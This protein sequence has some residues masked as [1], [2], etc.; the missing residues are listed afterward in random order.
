MKIL[1]TGRNGQVGFELGRALAPL[2]EICAVDQEDGDFTKEASIRELVR[3]VRPD[4]VANP[5][6]YTA[7]DRAESEPSLAHAVNAVAPGVIGEEADKLGALVIHYSTDYVFDGRKV[8]FYTEEDET[9]PLNVY[10]RSKRAGELALQQATTRHLILRTSW[11]V[12][13]HGSNFAKTILRLAAERDRLK[14]V[15]DQWGA[16]TS[17]ALLADVTAHLVRE[18]QQQGTEPFPYG[19]YHVVAG[20]ETTWC[21]YARFVVAEALADGQSLKLWPDAIEAIPSSAYPTAATRPAN[22]RLD[23]SKFRGVFHLS[24]PDW[25][26]GVRYVL[27]QLWDRP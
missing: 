2:G 10:G 24:L 26:D 20:G 16:P 23:T 6:A 15:A 13:A 8:G 1:L 22:S 19:L 11:V 18:W 4:V 3:R 5:A 25:R 27:R 17:A 21:D 14:V 9:K 12:G 7:V